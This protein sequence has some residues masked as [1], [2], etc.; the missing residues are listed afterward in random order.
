MIKA[1]KI[2]KIF[3]REALN[4]RQE[5]IVRHIFIHERIDNEECQRLCGSIKR[6][7]TRD[8]TG[9][10]EKDILEKKG[11]KKGTYYVFSPNSASKIRDIMGHGYGT[12]VLR[13]RCDI[14]CDVSSTVSNSRASGFQY[15]PKRA[16]ALFFC[17]RR[18]CVLF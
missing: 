17:A 13:Y 18:G 16:S 7:A 10:V 15:S 14:Y 8:L 5:K 4:K 12:L 9:L 3:A 2:S 1:E 6:T 11:E